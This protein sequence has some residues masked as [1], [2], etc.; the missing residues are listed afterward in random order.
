MPSLEIELA[1]IREQNL[2][3]IKELAAQRLGID[4]RMGMDLVINELFDAVFPPDS[5]ARISMQIRVEHK[6][7]EILTD[8]KKEALKNLLLQGVPR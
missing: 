5:D 3:L 1:D 4:P 8:A 7:K 6:I 2:V